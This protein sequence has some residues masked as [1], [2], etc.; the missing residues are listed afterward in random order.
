[1]ILATC[2]LLAA[3]GTKEPAASPDNAADATAS[4]AILPPEPDMA[5]AENVATPA[6][7][8]PTDAWI[9]KWVGVE[10]LVLEIAPGPDAGQYALKVTLLDGPANYVGTASGETIRFTR[11]GKEETIRKATGDETG[12]KYLAGKKNCLV[13]KQ[14]EGF[15]RD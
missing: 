13:I 4:N 9:G 6:A 14:G 3:C 1:M 2:A 11:D 12:L 5:V 10:G 7:P 8:L 15:C